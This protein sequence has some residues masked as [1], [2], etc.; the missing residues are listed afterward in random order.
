MA[1][2]RRGGAVK[3]GTGRWRRTRLFDAAILDAMRE[4]TNGRTW[5]RHPAPFSKT[6]RGAMR[7]AERAFIRSTQHEVLQ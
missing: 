3:A 2:A 5:R 6:R 4:L 1:Q 7:R